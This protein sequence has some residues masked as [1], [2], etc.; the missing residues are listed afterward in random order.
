MSRHSVTVDLELDENTEY[1][2]FTAEAQARI[3]AMGTTGATY[4]TTPVPAIALA[5]THLN[6]YSSDVGI[7]GSHAAGTAAQ[8]L[9]SKK[10]VIK[11]M[12][13]WQGQVQPA[14]DA[15]P[16]LATGILISQSCHFPIK[17]ESSFS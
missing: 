6:K 4:I 11:D 10:Q 12:K 15:A 7:A 13:A 8:A 5:Q 1:G 2:E 3:H 9:I 14:V 17:D 16:D